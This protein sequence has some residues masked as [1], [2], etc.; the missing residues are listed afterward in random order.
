MGWVVEIDGGIALSN[1]NT[2]DT[3]GRV[4]MGAGHRY[5]SFMREVRPPKS[6]F[7]RKLKQFG[8]LALN[9]WSTK[10]NT[11][12]M[13][14]PVLILTNSQGNE[15]GHYLFEVLGRLALVEDTLDSYSAVYVRNSQS[16]QK[17]Y[18]T[19]LG[20]D[21][22]KII[23]ADRMPSGITADRLI[24]PCYARMNGYLIDSKITGFLRK[25]LLPYADRVLSRGER[26]Y[27]SRS[28]AKHRR[29]LNEQALLPILTEY[30][31]SVVHLED[32]SVDEQISI[33]QFAKIVVGAHGTG[34]NNLLYCDPGTKV[35]EIFPG[36]NSAMGLVFMLSASIDLD[37]FYLMGSG[38]KG[39]R[40]TIN[41]YDIK[42]DP[43]VFRQQIELLL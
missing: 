20:L 38:V 11:I 1:G 3:K 15:Y 34:L 6:S 12:H 35:L 21:D 18:L 9:S 36:S 23:S 22:K 28:K 31:F 17:R 40:N 16:Y 7:G 41:W 8:P 10:L 42:I 37:Y 29:I 43:D 32:C 4:I 14:C 24:V 30:G 25:K 5:A 26:I 27:V 39:K 33:M 19:M 13:P 2:L